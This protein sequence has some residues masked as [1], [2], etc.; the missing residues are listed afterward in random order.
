M[1]EYYWE[2]PEGDADI[3]FIGGQLEFETGFSGRVISGDKETRA[4]YE[5]MR[6]H[7]EGGED[8]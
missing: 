3:S 7:Y 2:K 1:S 8:E 4:L 6:D 5:A